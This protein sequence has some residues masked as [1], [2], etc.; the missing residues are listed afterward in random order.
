[1]SGKTKVHIEEREEIELEKAVFNNIPIG[2]L[3]H[4]GFD[5]ENEIADHN[6]SFV[7]IGNKTAFC[8][9]ENKAQRIE[10]NAHV[11]R[12]FEMNIERTYED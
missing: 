9:E 6:R 3:F 10:Q 4:L 5:W 7:K 2:G 1:M 11:E 8:F 12:I